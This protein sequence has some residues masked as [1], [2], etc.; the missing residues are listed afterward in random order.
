MIKK[1]LLLSLVIFMA[2]GIIYAQYTTDNDGQT[3]TLERLSKI[4]NSG[5]IK[6]SSQHINIYTLTQSITIS[7]EDTLTLS[8]EMT[9]RCKDGVRITIAGQANI[10][11]EK[12]IIFTRASDSDTPDCLFLD[13]PKGEVSIKNV[14]FEYM[15]LMVSDTRQ[16]NLNNCTF[17][18][19][20]GQQAAALYFILGNNK[21]SVTDCHFEYAQKAA[22]GSSVTS[23]A[24]LDISNCTFLRNSVA[25][26]NIP[27]INLSAS[28]KI[29]ITDCSIS[30]NPANNMVGGIGISN[31]I[32]SENTQVTIERCHIADNR[33]GIGSVGPVNIRILDCTLTD[34]RY[35]SDP[36][37]G[38]SG[39]SLYDPYKK[40]DAY[41]KGNLIEG[42][43]WGV[44]I[45]G[46]K[47]VNLGRTSLHDHQ[48]P[49]YN[50]GG[51]IFRDNG[52]NGMK[53][54]L[55]NNSTIT[56]YA[57]G[58]IWNVT[59]QT[60]DEIEKVITHKVDNSSLGEVI[61]WP[62][63][64]PTG[65]NLPTQDANKVIRTYTL[66]GIAIPYGNDYKGIQIADGRKVLIKK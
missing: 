66:N 37:N 45:I 24:Q 54:D 58:N 19:H 5:V 59:N 13:T 9:L 33:Y 17:T 7:V 16:L 64:T 20:H 4:D 41:L 27:Q 25:N 49:T 10:G 44:T 51:N 61:F 32:G 21:A 30:G 40:T 29:N 3:Y 18:T 47:S 62:A 46:C 31:F 23:Q 43:L 48:A 56:V 38:G 15:G 8:D 52:N 63:G 12:P 53:Y 35:E 55:Y 65:I 26:Q 14:R 34:N 39:V 36:M 57:Q 28:E 42:S 50:P 2:R 60:K 22:I 6:E 1:V 11:G